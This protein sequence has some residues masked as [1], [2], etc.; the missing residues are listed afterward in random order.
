[1]IENVNRIGNF[2]S[3]E[4]HKLMKD[5]KTKGTIGAPGLTYIEEKNIERKLGRSVETESYSKDMAWGSFL[6]KRVFEMLEYGYELQSDKTDMHPTILYWAGSTDLIMPGI[7]IADIK[8]FQPKNF[9]KYSDALLSKDVEVLKEEFPKEYWQLVSN[10]IINGVS[11]AEA[12]AYMPYV[13]ELPEIR[14]M[15]EYYDEADQWK[16]RFI[17]ESPDCSLPYLP[18]D[19][20]YS[21]INRLEFDIPKQDIESLTERIKLAGT[22]L[23]SNSPVIIAHRDIELQSTIIEPAKIKLNKI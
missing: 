21:N 5:G 3:S 23:V 18:D 19:G 9:A 4:V 16:Y 7:K 15:A 17:A 12:I 2:T 1:M 11:K 13:S 10:A 22:M 8:C 14:E 6:E 20:Y